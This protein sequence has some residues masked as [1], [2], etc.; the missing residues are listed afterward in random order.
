MSA[1]SL[2]KRLGDLTVGNRLKMP[3]GVVVDTNRLVTITG[4]AALTADLHSEKPIVMSAAAGQALTLPASTG[5]GAHFEL[6]VGTTITSNTSTIKVANATDVMAGYAIQ[7]Q[8][9]GATVQMF[10]T[11]ASSDTITM[12]G[13][14]TGGIIGD[15]IELVDIKPGFWAVRM[16][17][18][19]TGAE[20]TPFS[21]TV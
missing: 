16:T 3:S 20:A 5:S 19:G 11:A 1:Q 2:W 6:I 7:S 4:A 10:E 8:D 18:A 9:A 12:D 15:R 13:S 21:A 14:T 17:A